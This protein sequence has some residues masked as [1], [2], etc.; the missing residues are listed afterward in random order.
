V[1]KGLSLAEGPVEN[2]GINAQLAMRL[3]IVFMFCFCFLACNRSNQAKQENR[4]TDSTTVSEARAESTNFPIVLGPK[5]SQRGRVFELNKPT[6][7]RL[8]GIHDTIYT[9]YREVDGQGLRGTGKFFPLYRSFH[10]YGFQ[11]D[12]VTKDSVQVIIEELRPLKRASEW[13]KTDGDLFIIRKGVAVVSDLY[14]PMVE[15]DSSLS[16]GIDIGVLTQSLGNSKTLLVIG[17]DA[18]PTYPDRTSFTA[19]G[20][21]EAGALVE[22]PG[23]DLEHANELPGAFYD[24]Q[25]ISTSRNVG[26]IS[27]DIPIRVDLKNC[28]FVTLPQDSG[29]DASCDVRNDVFEANGDTIRINVHRRPTTESEVRDYFLTKTDS[30]RVTRLIDRDEKVWVLVSNKA[31]VLGWIDEAGIEKLQLNG[32]D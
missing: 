21:N 25:I 16:G 11:I 7:I 28:S 5:T 17:R 15:Q 26:C 9:E 32:C 20:I 14:E 30:I 2:I 10:L 31:K 18:Y 13:E 29:Y 12:S 8:V 1:T 6:D 27:Y 4:K 24:G 22:F 19:Y 23:L 3:L